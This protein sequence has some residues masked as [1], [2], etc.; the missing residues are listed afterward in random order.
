LIRYVVR[1]LH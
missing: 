1:L